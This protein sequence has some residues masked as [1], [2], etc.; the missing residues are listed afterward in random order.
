MK[1]FNSAQCKKLVAIA[2]GLSAASGSLRAVEPSDILVFSKEPFLLRP[3][4]AVAE[5]YIDNVFSRQVGKADFITAVSPGLNFRL[6]KEAG[7]FIALDYG[8]SQRFYAT[9]D[10]LN[11]GDHA[12]SIRN[13]LQGQRLAMV[14]T[15]RMDLVSNPIGVVQ[16]TGFGSPINITPPVSEGGTPSVSPVPIPDLG[17]PVRGGEVLSTY[18]ER[19]VDSTSHYH[20][21]NLAYSMTEKTGV[22][23]QGQYS[24]TDYE[25]GVEL[26]DLTTWRGTGGFAFQAFPKTSFF[27]ETYYGRTTTTPNFIAPSIPHLSFIGGSLGA[28]GNFTEKITGVVRV[29]YESREFADSSEAPSSPVASLSLSYRVLPKTALSVTYDRLH[30]V[31]VQYAKQ[32]YTVNVL[33]G[34]VS[35]AIG[36]S[37]KWRAAIG[38]RYGVYAYETTDG[39][40]SPGYDSYSVYFNLEHQLQVWLTARLGYGLDAI[41]Y[42]NSGSGYDVNRLTLG[43]AIGY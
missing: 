31:S 26:Y 5:T 38:G 19:N 12:F 27:G 40:A 37:G 20:S 4:L 30:D 16:Q 42:G 14:G 7:N 41:R 32:S 15:D 9:Q 39:A 13:K 25:Q 10:D 17:S 21:Y 24:L 11:A 23:L 2:T 33:S 6:G 18:E 36:S 8:F 3:R 28:R 35:Q 1:I 34:Q 29:G 22:Y 43:L